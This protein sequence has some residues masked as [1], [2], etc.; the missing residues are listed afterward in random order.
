LVKSAME[1]CKDGMEDM[2]GIALKGFIGAF[3][4]R[5]RS[6]TTENIGLGQNEHMFGNEGPETWLMRRFSIDRCGLESAVSRMVEIGEAET[7]AMIEE[8]RPG[9]SPIELLGVKL[10][11]WCDGSSERYVRS[12]RVDSEGEYLRAACIDIADVSDFLR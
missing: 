8:G 10:K 9:A 11:L 7:A 6:E 4:D 5:V 3:W 12:V 2:P 1:S